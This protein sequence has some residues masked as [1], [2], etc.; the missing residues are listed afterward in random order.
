MKKNKKGIAELGVLV[1]QAMA[2][3]AMAVGNTG[4][5]SSDPA[6]LG[7]TCGVQ[8]LV[9]YSQMPH[10]KKDFRLRKAQTLCEEGYKGV[11]C[12]AVDSMTED[13]ILA[14]IKDDITTPQPVMRERLG[15]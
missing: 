13:E 8:G 12:S 2:I 10:V 6:T 1:V 9:A 7:F 3:V 14:Y 4:V 15:G 5:F 11:S